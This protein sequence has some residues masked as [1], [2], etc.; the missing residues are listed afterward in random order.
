MSRPG[1]SPIIV[2]GA[3]RSGTT[4]L[5]R[6]L[7]Q[8][9]DV[10]V[11]NEMRVFGWLHQSLNVLTRDPRFL[12]TDR[13][14]FIEHL[15]SEYPR[16]IEGFYRTLH[17]KAQYWGDKNPRYASDSSAGTLETVAELFPRSRFIHLVRDGRDVVVS[18]V[19]QG[20]GF[21]RAHRIWVTDVER[22]SAFGRAHAARYLEVRYEELVRDDAAAARKLFEFLGIDI[23]PDVLAFCEA[24]RTQRTP[25][26]GPGR[27]LGKGAL[28]SDWERLLAPDQQL[29]S[30]ELLGDR[31]VRY[32]YETTA[33]LRKARQTLEE[34]LSSI[35]VNPIRNV[36][37]EE[38]P[39][40]ARVAVV[41][42]GDDRLLFVADGRPAWHFPQ[43][44][45]GMNRHLGRDPSDAH[46]AISQLE[47]LRR[48]GARFL[49]V[50]G[51]APRWLD[52]FGEFKRHLD[53][54]YQRTWDDEHCILFR[55]G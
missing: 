20:R 16:V 6:I 39:E 9:P 49:L 1:A 54:R 29:R 28:S 48:R 35:S 31:L 3:P 18:L 2:Y 34:R 12:R 47:R 32:G 7:N 15:R 50:P 55:L 5:I 44:E 13:D 52:T 23:H 11:G 41:S 43:S 46:E 42:G 22:G 19:R 30:L 45:R 10:F 25:V 51:A 4:Y 26:S 21:D 33:S 38:V 14:R 40:D 8:H 36:I 27:D 53:A 24:Q 37:R 17:P